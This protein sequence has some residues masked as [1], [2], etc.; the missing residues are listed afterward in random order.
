MSLASVR[1]V[2]L[3]MVAFC[4]AT[5]IP[6]SFFYFV[7]PAV[8]RQAGHSAEVIG[9]VALVGLPYALRVFWAPLVDRIAEGNAARY[10]A[11]AFAMLGAAIISIL[12]FVSVNPR[13]DLAATL[14]IATL[15]FIF[16]ATGLT[17][18]DGYVLSTLGTAGRERVTAYQAAGFT[19]GAIVLGVGAIATDG[20]EWTMLVLLLAAT[21]AILTVPL[22]ILPNVGPSSETPR[23]TNL[24]HGISH[25][26]R[27]P[28]VRRRIAVSV[29]AHG[30]LGLPAGYL[31][32]LQVD[33]GLTPGQIG[34]FGAI[35]SNICGLIAAIATG[36]FVA[37]FGSW[38]TLTVV[39]LAGL[40]IFSTTAFIHTQLNGPIFAVSMALIVMT[41][42]YSYIVPYR[43]LILTICD[44]EKGATQA[45]FLSCFDVMISLLAASV[46]G[47]IV[48]MLG[49]TGLFALSAALCCS[50]ALVAVW[51]LRRPDDLPLVQPAQ[52]PA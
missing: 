40:A 13:V 51:A 43:A 6:M 5:S 29:L 33:A 34:L 3:G 27:R 37:R 42:G 9:L 18:V 23:S 39:I 30:G 16:L 24:R 38:R 31:A 17:A 26:V 47:V 14:C 44:V 8:L 49:L 12:G 19:L 41:L 1:R 25:F 28:A 48:G 52:V 20:I 36:A 45:A 21:T 11:L 7:L 4:A 46:A 22:L 35:G 15:V 10:R 2:N 50:G 32:V